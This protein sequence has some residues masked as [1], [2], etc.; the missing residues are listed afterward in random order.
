VALP[1][2]PGNVV[3]GTLLTMRSLPQPP[4]HSKPLPIG[5]GAGAAGETDLPGLGGVSSSAATLPRPAP[6]TLGAIDLEKAFKDPITVDCMF[7]DGYYA[8]KARQL[9]LVPKKQPQP[10]ALSV[11]AVLVSPQVQL[12]SSALKVVAKDIE[13]EAAAQAQSSVVTPGPLLPPIQR[14]VNE[15][16]QWM[17]DQVE[18]RVPETAGPTP[19]PGAAHLQRKQ[20]VQK[21]LANISD[22]LGRAG[23]IAG[24]AQADMVFERFTFDPAA[25]KFAATTVASLQGSRLA[26]SWQDPRVCSLCLEGGEDGIFCRML[27]NYDGSHVHANC[28]RWSPDIVEVEGVLRNAT[29]ARERAMRTNCFFCNRKGATVC[30]SSRKKCRRAFHLR[31]AMLSMCVLM[32]TMPASRSPSGPHEM[33]CHALCPEHIP[34]LADQPG[35]KQLW[36][37]YEP[38][39]PLLMEDNQDANYT[40]E[41]LSQRR[42]DKAVRC[43][44]LTVLH[45]GKPLPKEPEF[46]TTKYIYAHH[47]K[48]TRIYWSGVNP[49]D[50]TLYAFEIFVA[51]DFECLD[52][53]Q[54]EYMRAMLEQSDRG[55]TR[56]SSSRGPAAATTGSDRPIFRVVALDNATQPIFSYSVEFA[57]RTVINRVRAVNQYTPL[58]AD[59][60]GVNILTA[61]QFFGLGAPFVRKGTEMLPESMATMISLDRSEQRTLYAPVY[62]L[63]TKRDALVLQQQLLR[64]QDALS[65]SVNGCARADGYGQLD[66]RVVGKRVTRILAKAVD[67]EPA[68][69]K[70]SKPELNKYEQK[71]DEDEN[72][73]V[74]EALRSRYQEM[75]AA[76]LE[77]PYAKLDVRKSGIHGWGL[78]AKINFERNDIIVEYIG[79]KIRQVVADRREVQYE[80]EGVGSCYLFRYVL[81]S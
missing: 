2:L 68:A 73:R 78:F 42:S 13:E 67:G 34:T 9:G 64:S 35:L 50:R 47:F 26:P 36:Q 1:W 60:I 43:G 37:P 66:R 20:G 52:A 72:K 12:I 18:K 59:N 81:W 31:C 40:A 48:A 28:L 6:G 23:D 8:R 11:E 15:A 58:A 5:V 80:E 45:L 21:A 63:P 57:F 70:G 32:E 56:T 71:D 44:A 24:K 62:C 46:Y 49:L 3:R 30:C 74:N 33:Q 77:N 17:I 27:P 25:Y 79:Q 10:R 16:L 41:L 22:A 54:T 39:R 65:A 76:Y 53:A 55:T 38:M 75:T 51:G 29:A 14:Q 61:H 69:T 19:G 7:G 4:Y